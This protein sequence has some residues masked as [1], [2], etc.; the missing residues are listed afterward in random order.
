MIRKIIPVVV[1]LLTTVYAY[2]A[3]PTILINSSDGAA[4]D[5][6]ASGAG[7]STAIT[8]STLTTSASGLVVTLSGS[9]DLSNVLTDGSHVLFIADTQAGKRNFGKITAKD[10]S[11]TSTASVTVSD[12]FGVSMSSS[13]AWAIGG[14]RATI[15]GTTSLKLFSNNSASGDAM[16]GWVGEMGSGHTET[17]SATFNIRRPGDI[18]DGPITLRGDPDATTMPIL[19]FSNNGTAIALIEDGQVLRDF[20]LR[21]TNATKTASAGVSITN[22][23]GANIID[24]LVMD[25]S[26]NRFWKGITGGAGVSFVTVKNCKIGNTASYAIHAGGG[27]GSTQSWLILSSYIYDTD[28]SG[29]VVSQS[30][31]NTVIEN[32]IITNTG[33]EGIW[34]SN[35]PGRVYVT[36]NT[37]N[38]NTN[39]GILFSGALALTSH[40]VIKNNILS[41]NGS[42]GI[43]FS[44][45]ASYDGAILTLFELNN[46]A[47]YLNVS[48]AYNSATG[49]YSY[50]NCPWATGDLNLSPLYVNSASGNYSI[51][52]NLRA[53]GYPTDTIGLSN[54]RSYADVGA[55]QSQRKMA[56]GS[57]SH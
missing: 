20:E 30:A 19:T 44:N 2:S 56:V 3:Y 57:V 38:G 21:N 18:V 16:P 48:G 26:T 4:S 5:T 50:N 28:S 42:Y 55:A 54:T 51:G 8:G 29:I 23:Q 43:N 17:L 15:G 1:L 24:G 37:I 35:N 6:T 46:N 25:H 10:G 41:E 7:P 12:A 33:E 11:L 53:Q 36:N 9:P 14:V 13:I 31:G 27:T 47:T 34:F 40:G 39:S 49:S 52:T 45:A 22:N 32:C